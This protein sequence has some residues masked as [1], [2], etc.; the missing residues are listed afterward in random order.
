MIRPVDPG[1]AAQASRAPTP[2]GLDTGGT[3]FASVLRSELES[4]R[5]VR[6][7]NHALQRLRSRDIELSPEQMAAIGR[8]VDEAAA[9]G[10]RES[11]LLMEDVALIASVPNRTVITAMPAREAAGNVFTNIDSAVVVPGVPAAADTPGPAP[12]R[13]SPRAADRLMRRGT[14]EGL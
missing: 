3:G 9:K 14:L 13:E 4:A 6:F 1:L 12:L 11:L 10:G 5:E 7:S 8:A 2:L